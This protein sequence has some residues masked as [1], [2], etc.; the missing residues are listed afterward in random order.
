MFKIPTAKDAANQ[1]RNRQVIFVPNVG[2]IQI[3]MNT[4]YCFIS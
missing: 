4:R 3:R 1:D 2:N